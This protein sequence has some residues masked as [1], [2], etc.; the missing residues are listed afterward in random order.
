MIIGES[1]K[2][3]GTIQVAS[4]SVSGEVVGSITTT[5]NLELRPS[6]RVTGELNVAA[7]I[8]ER[9]AYFDGQVKMTGR[10]L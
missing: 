8:V 5:G 3:E 6:A 4:A 7:L 9:G 2:I 10:S 1:A